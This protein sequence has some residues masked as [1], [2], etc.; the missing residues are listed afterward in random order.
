MLLLTA[1]AGGGPFEPAALDRV[2]NLSPNRFSIVDGR[3]DTSHFGLLKS[4]GVA[5]AVIGAELF[6]KRDPAEQAKRLAELAASEAVVPF[7]L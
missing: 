4:N 6:G 3:I 2:R 1:P 5:L 7:G